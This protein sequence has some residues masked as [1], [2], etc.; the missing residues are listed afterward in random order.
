MGSLPHFA[1]E[2][3]ATYAKQNKESEQQQKSSILT[4]HLI[5]H[6]GELPLDEVTTAGVERYKAIKLGVRLAPK[7]VNNQLVVLRTALNCA[8]E[9]GRLEKTPRIKNL[10]T[11]SVNIDFLSEEEVEQLLQ[12]GGERS[13]N[14][15]IRLALRT[16]MRVG[17]VLALDWTD[18]D[19][20]H[21]VITVRRSYS[22]GFLSSTKS[23][24]IR[25]IPIADDLLDDLS[26]VRC[27][28]RPLVAE[29][30]GL[31]KYDVARRA[32][33]RACA[34]A[35]V[36]PVGWHVLRHTFASHLVIGGVPLSAVQMLLGHASIVTTQ[37]YTH[38]APN[39]LAE[40][41]AVLNRRSLGNWRSTPSLSPTPYQPSTSSANMA[42][43]ADS[44]GKQLESGSP[45]RT[46]RGG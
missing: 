28:S 39:H 16:G 43:A 14:T 11:T 6:F 36:R 22:H 21:R 35:G 42:E 2:W 25:H 29:S 3:L 41:V 7:T 30:G 34:R 18:I 40:A 5:P 4:N 8:R 12:D 46:W 31:V 9:W 20:E 26:A 32:L 44:R 38:L 27:S 10:R 24:K 17:E 23:R 33:L 19:L 1:R 13:W 15:L 37:R 45:A